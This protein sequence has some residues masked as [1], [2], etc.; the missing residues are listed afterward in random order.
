MYLNIEFIVPAKELTADTLVQTIDAMG[1][2]RLG[3]YAERTITSGKGAK[4]R[5]NLLKLGPFFFSLIWHE[6]TNRVT[7]ASVSWDKK[8]HV[9]VS[10]MPVSVSG[11]H[12]GTMVFFKNEKDAIE[13]LEGMNPSER[14]RMAVQSP[15]FS[16]SA[17]MFMRTY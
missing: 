15:D 8:K 12:D 16:G 5:G 1:V 4:Y 14:M 7:M 9:M 13:W 6:E 11:T 2:Q 10:E 17:V 3:G